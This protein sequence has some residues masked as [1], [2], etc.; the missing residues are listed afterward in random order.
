MRLTILVVL[1]LPLLLLLLSSAALPLMLPTVALAAG[2]EGVVDD[3]ILGFELNGV[4]PDG[5]WIGVVPG[6]GVK[7]CVG[8]GNRLAHSF[9][10]TDVRCTWNTLAVENWSVW[11]GRAGS[12][13]TPTLDEASGSVASTVMPISVSASS[14]E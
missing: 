5:V 7:T 11:E 6:T 14:Q 13:G 12:C 8:S 4:V 9:N 10:K 1:S 3:P 2:T